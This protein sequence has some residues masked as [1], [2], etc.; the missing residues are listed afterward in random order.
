MEVKVRCVSCGE[1]FPIEAE[2][3]DCYRCPGCDEFAC[4]DCLSPD[5]GLCKECCQP[6]SDEYDGF[7]KEE[8]TEFEKMV[9]VL[10]SN[11]NL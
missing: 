1:N 7:T 6:E 3:E 8:N 11:G 4:F 2:E 10:F 9:G 5:I